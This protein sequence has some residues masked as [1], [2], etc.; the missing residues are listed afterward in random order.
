MENPQTT[1]GS[2]S[3]VRNTGSRVVLFLGILLLAG[4]LLRTMY[5]GRA[6]YWIDE[7]NI[8]NVSAAMD[9]VKDIYRL[10]LERFNWYHVL[11][12]LSAVVHVVIKTVG[13]TGAFPPEWLARILFA[14]CST[15]SLYFFFLLGRTVRS[16][17]VGLWA[18]FLATFS[19]F[20]LFYSRE[21]Y[22][23]SLLIF[24]GAGC[25][26]TGLET[27]RRA[28]RPDRG[29]W[30]FALGYML[31]STLFLQT[32]M[33]ALLFLVPWT[34]LLGLTV[35]L[36]LGW[37]KTF[38][39]SNVVFWILTLGLSFA[40]FSPF[41]IRMFGGY[42]TT[43]D[44]GAATFSLQTVSAVFG[45]MGW[46]EYWWCMLP[47]LFFL[48]VGV[49]CAVRDWK[50][51]GHWAGLLIVAQMLLYF[52]LQSWMLVRTQ[53]RFEV[54]YYHGMFPL[55]IVLVGWG[56]EQ[57]LGWLAVKRNLPVA[58]LRG[59]LG[60]VILIW[61]LPSLVSVCALQCRGYSNYR[62]L[63]EWIN[64][65]LATNGVYS[66]YN[67]T[68]MRAVPR[69]YP[70]P[71]RIPTSV[72]DWSSAEDFKRADPPG[73]AVSLFTRFPLTVF[74]EFAPDDLLRPGSGSAPIPRDQLF[75]RHEWITDAAWSRLHRL[76]TFPVGEM[77]PQATNA[78]MVLISYNRP[79]DLPALAAKRNQ[80][81]YSY[82]G[83]EW[84][85]V[86][87]NQMNGWKITEHSGTIFIGNISD[88]PLPGA[89]KIA[90]LGYPSGGLVS[91]YGPDGRKLLDKTDIPPNYQLLTLPVTELQ[92]GL[93]SCR[94]EILPAQGSLSAALLVYGIVIEG[95]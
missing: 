32:H 54:R 4:L 19:V 56:I 17:A 93:N 45:R 29:R 41:L 22:A 62:G 60:T 76:K 7:I 42:T 5:L 86:K 23:Y 58:I 49:F 51:D 8:I 11:P 73:R 69:V 87:D 9:S 82:F 25:L 95:G 94:M 68:E 46:G 13:Y 12:F 83:P 15:V 36:S 91:V 65:N 48:L 81:F 70:T 37:K 27:V 26:W 28:I 63:A 40:V 52:A 39:G 90:V 47:F 35:L 77:L 3:G 72:A 33:S 53:S 89:I 55:M 2:G 92:P 38:E 24:F 88:R 50:K 20:H 44:P 14:L 16:W 30:P 71:G 80:T 57:S 1:L 43:D 61:A 75:M 21:V 67:S 84:G 34:G 74:A 78:Q 10:E 59:T 64:A 18:M 6:S 66:F 85:Y 79:E 31:F